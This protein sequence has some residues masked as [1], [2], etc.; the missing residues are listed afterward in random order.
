LIFV[1]VLANAEW[2][3]FGAMAPLRIHAFR[4]STV[5][6]WRRALFVVLMLVVGF[7]PA[8]KAVCDLEALATQL[9]GAGAALETAPIVPS[10]HDDGGACCEHEPGAFVVPAKLPVA[11]ATLALALAGAHVAPPEIGF[12]TRTAVLGPTGRRC[13]P[14]PPESVFRRVPRLLI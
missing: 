6:K 11:D 8:A 13:P 9:S 4:R 14:A 10:P 3:I 2:M 5:A 1:K 12:I 7:A